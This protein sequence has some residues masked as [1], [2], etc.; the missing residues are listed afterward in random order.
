MFGVTVKTWKGWTGLPVLL[1]YCVNACRHKSSSIGRGRQKKEAAHAFC[2]CTHFK[3]SCY[4]ECTS[5]PLYTKTAAFPKPDPGICTEWRGAVEVQAS[6]PW[7]TTG[8]PWEGCDGQE[9]KSKATG[10]HSHWG[11]HISERELEMCVHMCV[12]VSAC[13]H[14]HPSACKRVS[15]F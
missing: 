1:W 15:D 4:L 9:W 7:G 5:C 8:S 3:F 11:L 12:Y 6:N 2:F 13:R 14:P 10:W